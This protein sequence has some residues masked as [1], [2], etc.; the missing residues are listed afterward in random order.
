MSRNRILEN[1][2]VPFLPNHPNSCKPNNCEE[3]M[4]RSIHATHLSELSK[5][6][7]KLTRMHKIHTKPSQYLRPQLAGNIAMEK[8][9]CSRFR[10]TTPSWTSRIGHRENTSTSQIVFRWNS[11]AKKAP[12]QERNLWR[13]LFI[14]IINNKSLI[15]PFT[16]WSNMMIGTSHRVTAYKI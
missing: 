5:V 10:W 8:Q 1:T 15:H 16:W 2:V 11:I 14:L 9:M 7:S 13:D 6:M 4:R 3:Q 12:H